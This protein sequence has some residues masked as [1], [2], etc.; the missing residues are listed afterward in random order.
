MFLTRHLQAKRQAMTAST[1]ADMFQLTVPLAEKVL[2]PLLVYLFLVFS[3][4]LVG[5]RLMAQLNPFDLVVLLI[6]SNT[7]QNAIIGNDNTVS[8]GLIGAITLLLANS[9]VVRWLYKHERV[10]RFLEGGP[11]TL[12]EGGTLVEQ[13]LRAEGISKW[14]VLTAA[15]KQ[16]FD[17]LSEIDR[18][19]IEPGGAIWFFRRKATTDDARQQELLE[20]LARIEEKLGC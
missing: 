15:H 10:E 14:E 5:K 16:G 1:L 11:D 12:I 17:T 3:L 2:R 9:L 18:A 20:R 13:T 7:V 8:G 19:V 4:R 6:L